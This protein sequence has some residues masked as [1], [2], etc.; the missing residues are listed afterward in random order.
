M[1]LQLD[2]RVHPLLSSLIAASRRPFKRMP[3]ERL[4]DSPTTVK[5]IGTCPPAG[6]EIETE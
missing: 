5:T 3:R 1:L 6:I 2:R 4:S